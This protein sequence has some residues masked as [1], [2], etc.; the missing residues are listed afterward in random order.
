M[1][2]FQT[3]SSRNYYD[4]QQQ[5]QPCNSPVINRRKLDRIQQWNAE[6]HRVSHIRQ[7]YNPVSRVRLQLYLW[8]TC[9]SLLL[10]LCISAV[11]GLAYL[12]YLNLYNYR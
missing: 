10:L 8:F 3:V 1:R 4:Q 5:Q 12:S 11:T 2:T 9:Y 6:H 7:G